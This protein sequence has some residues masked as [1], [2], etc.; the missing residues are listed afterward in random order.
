MWTSVDYEL[1]WPRELLRDELRALRDHPYRAWSGNEVELL[2]TEA[3]HAE[4][5]AA[6]FAR[7]NSLG[8]WA[9][10]PGPTRTWIADL[11]EH[12]HELREYTP[13]RPYWAA[14][15]SGQA[16]A[17]VRD[18]AAAPHR[19]ADLIGLL[20][21]CG[22]LARDFGEPCVDDNPYEHYAG[23]LNGEL[24]RRLGNLGHRQL[25][26]PQPETWDFDTFYGLIEVFHDLV[27]RPRRRWY[28]DFGD[29]GF[30]FVDFDTDAGRRVYRSLVNG[31]L[32][33]NAVELRLADT[34]EDA[35][36]LVHVVD[37]ARADLVERALLTPD[38][39]VAG[40]VEHAIALFRRR[41]AGAEDKRSAVVTLAG[42][43]EGRRTVI[44]ETPLLTSADED[45]LFHIANKFALR[46]RGINQQRDYDEAFLDWIFWWY[47]ATVE[48]TDQILARDDTSA[49]S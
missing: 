17:P 38:P 12:L 22:Y 15:R 16:E 14:R 42:I 2:L 30:H 7:L 46:H 40:R 11:L 28:H 24:C 39:D 1:D 23:D 6:E 34:G 44:K 41:G 43:L 29:C 33:E 48:L 13:P 32:A 5:P 49:A 37:E 25:W 18:P 45:A 47:L 27:A 36:R 21:D 20:R 26:P 4:I 8:E 35:G 3:F 31:L 19:F 9:D 10:D